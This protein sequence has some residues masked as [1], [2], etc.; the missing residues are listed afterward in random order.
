[1]T[2]EFALPAKPEDL[3]RDGQAGF[4]DPS[5]IADLSSLAEGPLKEHVEGEPGCCA[6]GQGG[7]LAR[8]CGVAKGH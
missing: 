2:V 8:R 3:H 5:Q 1:M 4:L 7:G 6:A